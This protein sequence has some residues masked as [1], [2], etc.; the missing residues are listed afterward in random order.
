[1]DEFE[2][3]YMIHKKFHVNKYFKDQVEKCINNRFGKVTQPF[4]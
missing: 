1:M 3:G 4:I 2:I